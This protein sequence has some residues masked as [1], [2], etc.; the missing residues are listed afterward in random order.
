MSIRPLTLVL[1]LALSLGVAACDSRDYD[2]EIA[3]LQ[4]QLGD[5]TS[6]LEATRS[7]NESLKTQLEE[8]RAQSEQAGDAAAGLGEVAAAKIRDQLSSAMEK[9]SLT[10]E[11]L[12]ALEAEPD[13]PADQ[14]TEAV[15]VLRTDVQDI[16]AS[17]EAAASELGIELQAAPEP[18]A[19][20]AQGDATGGAQAPAQATP[21]PEQPAEPPKQE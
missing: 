16:V 17:L 5:T 14:R 11:R 2:A 20:P 19:G 7:E 12:G 8:V 10:A 3:G 13:A 18:A 6:E 1:P 4:G 9:A 21:A 15:G